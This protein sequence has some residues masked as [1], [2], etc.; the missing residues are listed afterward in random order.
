MT[1]FPLTNRKVSESYRE[2]TGHDSKLTRLPRHHGTH[3]WEDGHGKSFIALWGI[4]S[5][6][7]GWRYAGES[8]WL[9]DHIKQTA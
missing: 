2:I 8:Y 9:Y 7:I 5:K 3:A 6:L 4:G 1:T